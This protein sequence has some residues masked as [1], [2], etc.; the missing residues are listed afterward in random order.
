MVHSQYIYIYIYILQ[1]KINPRQLSYSIEKDFRQASFQSF[2]ICRFSHPCYS[3]LFLTLFVTWFRYQKIIIC[4]VDIKSNGIFIYTNWLQ[5]KTDIL[6]KV[7]L[8]TNNCN[9]TIS[10]LY[11]LFHEKSIY[12]FKYWRVRR[13]SVTSLRYTKEVVRSCT[14]ETKMAKNK[15]E[16]HIQWSVKHFTEK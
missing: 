5:N 13:P 6:L 7:A 1:C 10:G 11:F 8:N 14:L 4:I 9:N 2:Q 15:L 16:K 3:W 12:L